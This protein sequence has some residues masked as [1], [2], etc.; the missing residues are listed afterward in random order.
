MGT[1]T[2][3]RPSS[4]LPNPG[5]TVDAEPIRDYITNVLAFLESASLKSGN[6]VTDTS[7]NSDAVLVQDVDQIVESK[8]DF[9]NTAAGGGGLR[10]VVEFTLNPSSGSS[11]DDDGIRIVLS[12][13]DSAAAKKDFGYFDLLFSD[14][15]PGTEDAK[16]SLKGMVAGSM[17][18]LIEIS[19]TGVD[20]LAGA[21]FT[22]NGAQIGGVNSASLMDW[23]GEGRETGT[24]E[25]AQRIIFVDLDDPLTLWD[26]EAFMQQLQGTSFHDNFGDPPMHGL[27]F[28]TEGQTK[29]V[30]W[31]RDTGAAYATVTGAANGIVEDAT[32]V[33][34]GVD[35]KDGKWYLCGTG[36]ADVTMLD[37]LQDGALK[38]DTSGVSRYGGTLGDLTGTAGWVVQSSSP[39]IVNATVYD[40]A[41]TRDPDEVD[42]FGRPKSVW[43]CGTDGGGSYYSE[44]LGAIYDSSDTNDWLHV[45]LENGLLAATISDATRDTFGVRRSVLGIAADS[46]ALDESYT[47]AGADAEDLPFSNSAVGERAAI[48]LGRSWAS[49]GADVL[50]LPTDEG[51]VVAHMHPS[52]NAGKGGL[53]RL[54]EDYASPYM[55]GDVRGCWPLHSTADVSPAGHTLTNNNTVTFASGGPAGSY[56]EFNGSNTYLND[57]VESGYNAGTTDFSVA[58]WFRSTSATNPGSTE[59]IWY[60]DD[61]TPT[62]Y[63]TLYFT[64]SGY[65]Y[66]Q[67]SDDGG[68]SS[69]SVNPSVDVYDGNWHYVVAQRNSGTWEMWADGVKLGST[70][71]NAAAA[72]LSVDD[73]HIGSNDSGASVFDGDIGGFVYSGTALT[74]RE[75][76]AEYARGLRRLSTTATGI[77]ANTTISDNDIAAV[78]ADPHSRY[79]GVLGDDKAFRIFDEFAVPVIADTYQGTAARDCAIKSMPKGSDPHYVIAGSDEIETVQPDTRL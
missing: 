62:D 17:T 32:P 10:E 51:A 63:I 8:K 5:S 48:L 61:G 69:D 57:T 40:I 9:V 36:G 29:A 49:E 77:D 2:V 25:N 34:T 33:L 72:A 26:Y 70:A 20:I 47:N 52:D 1:A 3:T 55:K 39:A 38:W 28:I 21:A 66:F 50:V 23:N 73:L 30:W 37:L 19:S 65:L 4:S 45:A 12:G 75:I 7:A 14:V 13:D 71:V 46:W 56:A 79:V 64:T 53:I 60:L 68:S 22:V 6:V 18:E 24:D 67:I 16:Y 31:D 41:V 74:E 11:A 78:A 58:C 42:E 44:Y 54:H 35:W 27:I 59:F 43:V 15:S 76:K